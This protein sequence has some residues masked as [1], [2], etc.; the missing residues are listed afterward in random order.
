MTTRSRVQS[1][2]AWSGCVWQRLKKD[3]SKEGA[4]RNQNQRR[5]RRKGC[6]GRHETDEG[7][8]NGRIRAVGNHTARCSQQH[9]ARQLSWNKNQAKKF[10]RSFCDRA[11]R[12]FKEAG[13]KQ[14]RIQRQRTWTLGVC[15][16]VAAGDGA[17]KKTP[18]GTPAQ[19]CSSLIYDQR[20]RHRNHRPRKLVSPSSRDGQGLS[21]LRQPHNPAWLACSRHRA[22]QWAVCRLHRGRLRTGEMDGVCD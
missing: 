4:N 18:N 10:P 3:L 7:I 14:I 6:G 17:H 20:H 8:F 5:N 11:R 9:P 21:S 2:P 15:K 22:A 16:T 1:A 19:K 12:I 13:A